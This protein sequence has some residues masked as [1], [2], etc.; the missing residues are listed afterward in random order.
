[1]TDF[2]N[3]NLFESPQG[4]LNSDTGWG[5]GG[6]AELEILLEGGVV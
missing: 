6:G 5:E 1:M 2:F 4:F 3:G